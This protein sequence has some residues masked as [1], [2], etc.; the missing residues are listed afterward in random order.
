MAPI[1]RDSPESQAAGP[2][3]EDARMTAGALKPLLVG[4]AIG[5]TVAMVASAVLVVVEDRV[6]LRAAR[7]VVR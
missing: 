1:G 5:V 2:D 3:T 7:S 4:I 6:W